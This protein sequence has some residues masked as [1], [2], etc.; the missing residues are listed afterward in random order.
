MENNE[1]FE[2]LVE[3]AFCFL[4]KSLEE[5]AQHQPKYSAINFYAA[6]ELFLK[7]RLLH[8]DWKL[9]LSDPNPISRK[10]FDQGNF[11]SVNLSKAH[12]C[13]KSMKQ[14]LTNDEYKCFSELGNHRNRI[15]HFFHLDQFDSQEIQNI[16]AEQCLAWYYLHPILAKKWE[17]I[18]EKYK[19]QISKYNDKMQE[20]HQYRLTEKFGQLKSTIFG[21]KKAGIK[22]H[23]CPSCKR[24]ALEENGDELPVLKCKCLVC[25]LE[26]NGVQITC[27]ACNSQQKLIGQPEHQCTS[28]SCS[29]SFTDE[30]VKKILLAWHVVKQDDSDDGYEANCGECQGE[31]SVA[32]LPSGKW[33]CSSCFVQFEQD[34]I[35]QCDCC[36]ALTTETL[37]DSFWTGCEH[38]EG[39]SRRLGDK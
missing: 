28:S 9:I 38:C 31:L 35:N 37:R 5:F 18:F 14:G 11:V 26:I 22:F 4:D 20:Q 3:N 16:V 17:D 6:I 15:V 27:T 39:E 29:S 13:L 32:L 21:K 36:N 25:S 10:E 23:K 1:T 33:M 19:N 12:K 7:A 2:N 34:D 30:D 8:E 24:E